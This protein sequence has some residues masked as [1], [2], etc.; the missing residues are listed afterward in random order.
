MVY[1][2]LVNI[3]FLAAG[4]YIGKE[5]GRSL[6]AADR[7]RSGAEQTSAGTAERAEDETNPET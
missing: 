1:R 3:A 6:A 4:Y 7:L 5:V 2:L